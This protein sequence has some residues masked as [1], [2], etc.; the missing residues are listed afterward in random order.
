MKPAPPPFSR[1]SFLALGSATALCGVLPARLA[2]SADEAE[3]AR[4]VYLRDSREAGTTL[5]LVTH[6]PE[7]AA[8][9]GRRIRLHAGRLVGDD[10]P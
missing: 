9:C 8:R 3:V 1:R 4:V 2:F 6:E 7:L 5:L 10:A